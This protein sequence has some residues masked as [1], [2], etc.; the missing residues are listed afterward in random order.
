M[1]LHKYAL[2]SQTVDWTETTDKSGNRTGVVVGSFEL[3]DYNNKDGPV[4]TL[5]GQPQLEF[6]MTI[7]PHDDQS[8]SSG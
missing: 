1:V 4:W 8:T 5:I 7:S 3:W 6:M 2:T